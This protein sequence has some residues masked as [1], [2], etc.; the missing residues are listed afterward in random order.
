MMDGNKKGCDPKIVHLSTQNIRAT[1]EFP[2]PYDGPVTKDTKRIR[3]KI[4][5]E[6][7]PINVANARTVHKLQGRS[8]EK[9]VISSW[10]YTGNWVYVVLSRCSTLNGIF[11]R[12]RLTKTRPMSEKCIQFHD[13]FRKNKSP[14]QLIENVYETRNVRP[15]LT[16]TIEGAKKVDKICGKS[17]LKKLC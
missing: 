16:N 7:F 6:Q 10:D 4:K 3:R 5:F 11:I 12:N 1:V 14:K 15:R 8:I 9:L 17:N 13:I 2:I